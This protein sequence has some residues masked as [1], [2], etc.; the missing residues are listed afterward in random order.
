[1]EVQVRAPS[2]GVN[3]L[4]LVQY[5]PCLGDGPDTDFLRGQTSVVSLK[6]KNLETA[7]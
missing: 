7:R 6:K 2:P 4:R 3:V 5:I 1:M